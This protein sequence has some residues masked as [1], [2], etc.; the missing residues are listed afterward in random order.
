[1]KAKKAAGGTTGNM[2]SGNPKA[3]VTKGVN[4]KSTNKSP[5]VKK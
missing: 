2:K 4:K 3:T 1:M 5:K